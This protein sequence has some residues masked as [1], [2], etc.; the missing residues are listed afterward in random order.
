MKRYDGKNA[1]W[2]ILLFIGFN[3]LPLGIFLIDSKG[4]NL[5]TII[6]L[7][8]YYLFD[9]L[10]VPILCRNRIDLYDDY[11]L[12]Y[13]GFSK[14]KINISDI[15]TIEKTNDM[16][17]SSANSLDRIYIDTKEKDFMVSLEDNEVFISEINKRKND[18]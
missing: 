14:L 8:I 17:A 7:V 6:V 4:I 12:F 13:Y 1:I 15:K 16:S 10:W 11:F 5:F 2:F 3:L 9:L 18:K